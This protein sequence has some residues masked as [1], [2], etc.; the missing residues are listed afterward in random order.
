MVHLVLEKNALGE[1][2]NEES[3]KA[4]FAARK[5]VPPEKLVQ[6]ACIEDSYKKLKSGLTCS[7]G[8]SKLHI[9]PDGR[10]S[11]CPYD[12][13]HIMHQ[14]V[15]KEYDVWNELNRVVNE[16]SCHSMD[17]CKIPEILSKLAK[18]G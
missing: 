8:I 15:G 2:Q 4:W 10:V 5:L 1:E 7:A 12:S 18:I 9:W 13:K 3:M 14:S 16:K 11:G 17:H 6:D